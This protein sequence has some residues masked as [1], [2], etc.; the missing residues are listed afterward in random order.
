[1]EIYQWCISNMGAWWRISKAVLR[2]DKQHSLKNKVHSRLV[3]VKSYIGEWK[4][5]YRFVCETY[6]QLSILKTLH[7]ATHII[8]KEVLLTAKLCALVEFRVGIKKKVLF[9]EKIR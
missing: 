3:L 4:G 5:C 6:K 8:A 9:C 1:M 7:H 2:K